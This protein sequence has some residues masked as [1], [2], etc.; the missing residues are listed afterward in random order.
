LHQ[1]LVYLIF[2]ISPWVEV[3]R[4]II[5]RCR[6][7]RNGPCSSYHKQP[8]A[9]STWD[10]ISHQS[11]ISSWHVAISVANKNLA[12]FFAVFKLFHVCIKTIL[13]LKWFLSTQIIYNSPVYCL[14][15]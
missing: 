11:A 15:Y 8:C 6:G 1:R 3:S 10:A 2:H 9:F 13:K 4:S 12:S 14:Q 7:T 5:Q